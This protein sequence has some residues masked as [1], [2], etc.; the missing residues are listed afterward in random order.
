MPGPPY[1][2]YHTGP[3]L[4]ECFFAYA[5][6]RVFAREY[7]PVF[8][9]AAYMSDRAGVIQPALL[10]LSPFRRYFTVCQ[11]DLAPQEILPPDTL[12]FSAGGLYRGP[13]NV[14]VP[15]VCSR[16]RDPIEA[17]PKDVFCSFVGTLTHRTRREIWDTYR[18]DPAFRFV[19]FDQWTLDVPPARFELFTQLTERSRF[20]LCPRG[21]GATSFRLYEAMQLGSVPVYVSDHHHLPW[22]DEIDWD[23]ITVVVRPD[24]IPHLGARLRAIDEAS[25]Q[26]MLANIR[27]VY[28]DYFS[29]AGVCRQIERRVI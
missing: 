6:D 26:R 4:E 15:L 14:P 16:L 19:V 29:L 24:E 27:R 21:F 10:S 18:E 5:R 17:K 20:T 23:E 9:T 1:P 3:A 11:H 2:P 12:V 28:D 8:W 7:I 25:Y 13:G 22:A